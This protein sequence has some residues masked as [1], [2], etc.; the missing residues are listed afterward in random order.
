[1]V[2]EVRESVGG[3]G[4]VALGAEEGGGVE[5][6]GGVGGISGLGHV[7]LVET[8]ELVGCVDYWIFKDKDSVL[9]LGKGPKLRS[10]RLLSDS[11]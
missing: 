6:G 10:E 11:D 2:Q 4:V 8:M 3:A 1:M 5:W 7:F 9:S